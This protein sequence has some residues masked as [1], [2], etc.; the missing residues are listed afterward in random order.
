MWGSFSDRVKV[1]VRWFEDAVWSR[2]TSLL[3]YSFMMLGF[4][5]LPA[6]I[7]GCSLTFIKGALNKNRNEKEKDMI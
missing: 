2:Q 7:S 6:V 1:Q 4:Q 3:F 5:R